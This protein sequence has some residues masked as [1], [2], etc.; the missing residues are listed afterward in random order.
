MYKD[1]PLL[2]PVVSSEV[3]A[4]LAGNVS[5]LYSQVFAELIV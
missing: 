3:N 5:V 1:N 4:V 2:L